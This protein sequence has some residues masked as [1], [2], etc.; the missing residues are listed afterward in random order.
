MHRGRQLEGAHV[1]PIQLGERE[2]QS[3]AD[4]VEAS[5]WLHERMSTFAALDEDGTDLGVSQSRSTLVRVQRVH[6]PARQRAHFVDRAASSLQKGAG[7]FGRKAFLGGQA[8]RP[9]VTARNVR[10]DAGEFFLR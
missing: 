8:A 10:R 5:D 4:G 7:V 2:L 3:S 1:E 9:L 6:T